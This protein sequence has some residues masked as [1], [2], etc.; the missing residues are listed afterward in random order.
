VPEVRVNGVRLYYEEHGAGEAIL[1]IHGTGSSAAAWAGAVEELARRGRTIAYDRRGSSRSE[2]PEPYVTDVHEQADDAAELIEALAAS[3]AIVIGRSYGVDTALDL[4]LRYPE[5]VRAL[6]LLEG[7]E[8]VTEAG[9]RWLAD[10]TERVLAAA[11]VDVG[12]VGETLLRSVLGDAGWEGLSEPAKQMFAA[13]GPAI[14]AELRGGLLDVGIAE[15]GAVTQPTLLVT[16]EDSVPVYAEVVEVMV[17]AMPS[18]RAVRVEGGHVIDP[19]HPAV[20]A[21]VDEVL[22]GA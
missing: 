22:S 11:E 3:P 1:C 15:L 13:N 12:A 17:A 14:A 20:L 7:A 5:R 4:A 21:F 10:L 9:G 6:A 16:G 18:A 8:L 2:R 19:A